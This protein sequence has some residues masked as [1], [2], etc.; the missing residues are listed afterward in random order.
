MIGKNT[1]GR[2]GFYLRAVL[3]HGPFLTWAVFDLAAGRFR[4]YLW[5][6]LVHGPFWSFPLS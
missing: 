6:V 1:V 5:A 4:P 2:F 3:V